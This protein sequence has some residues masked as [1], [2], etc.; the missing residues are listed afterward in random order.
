MRWGVTLLEPYPNVYPGNVVYRCA[1]PDGTPAV[2]KTEPA[3]SSDDEFPS[4]INALVHY[5][6][7]GMVR[8]FEVAREER[9]ILM[10]LVVPGRALWDARIS[11]TLEAIASVMTKLR[12]VPP[13]PNTFPSVAAYHRAWPN[14]R[15]LYGGP[16]PIEADLFDIGERLFLELCETSASPV[17]LHGDLHYGNVLSSDREGWLAIDPKGLS[18]EPCYEVG[19][20]FRNRVDELYASS[21]PIQAMRRRVEALADLTGFDRERIRLWALSQA[22]LSEVWSADDPNRPL[23]I[24][25]R[26]ARLLWSIG[27]LGKV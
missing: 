21:D 10:E 11:E 15:R 14:H 3:R 8:V 17:V 20:L 27:P 4:G 16:G 26:A 18:G 19:A 1:L 25:M 12:K 24:D 13:D 7:R 6:G 23:H 2:I 5:G 22:V 9:V